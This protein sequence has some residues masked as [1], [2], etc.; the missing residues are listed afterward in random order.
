MLI[1]QSHFSSRLLCLPLLQKTVPQKTL[2]LKFLHISNQY[3]L[4]IIRFTDY[5]F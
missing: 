1:I 4:Q 3:F 2:T 5:F